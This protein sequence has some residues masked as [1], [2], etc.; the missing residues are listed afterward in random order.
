MGEQ[1]VDPVTVDKLPPPVIPLQ[2]P[3]HSGA[4]VGSLDD[5]LQNCLSLAPKQPRK[6]VRKMLD[7]AG[8]TLRFSAE[9]DSVLPVDRYRRFILC[10]FLE[11]DSVSIFEPARPNSGMR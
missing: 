7:Q 3:P 11:D 10:Y 8:R 1:H 6:D 9:L 4:A 5:S 2:V